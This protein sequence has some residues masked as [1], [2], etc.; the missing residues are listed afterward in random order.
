MR[1]RH[2]S[3]L[4]HYSLLFINKEFDP[5]VTRRERSRSLCSRV[6]FLVLSEVIAE[7]CWRKSIGAFDVGL[8]LCGTKLGLGKHGCRELLSAGTVGSR[9]QEG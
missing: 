1:C 9:R 8:Q 2:L 4:K 6:A 7:L 3:L 5:G